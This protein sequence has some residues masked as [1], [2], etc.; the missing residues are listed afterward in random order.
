MKYSGIMN[1]KD[2]DFVTRFQ[3]SQIV[4][5]DPYNEDFYAQVFKVIH[6]KTINGVQ[7][8]T[9]QNNSIAQAYLDHSGH[10]LGVVIREPMLLYKECNNK[11]KSSYCC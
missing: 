3:L 8:S 4:T 10:R 1:P 6:P 7:Q 11:F 2:K 9:Q 5:E